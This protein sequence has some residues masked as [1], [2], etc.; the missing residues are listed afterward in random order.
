ME[1]SRGAT[2]LHLGE[3]LPPPLFNS[4]EVQLRQDADRGPLRREQSLAVL[5]ELMTRGSLSIVRSVLTVTRSRSDP[6]EL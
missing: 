4:A 3:F 1:R 6:N 2:A 5:M